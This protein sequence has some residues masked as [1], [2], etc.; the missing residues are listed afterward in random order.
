M[1][2]A[3]ALASANDYQDRSGVWFKVQAT[4]IQRL[5]GNFKAFKKMIFAY[6]GT[7]KTKTN[8]FAIIRTIQSNT[9]TKAEFRER[10]L[11]LHE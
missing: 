4:V 11:G 2:D 5:L 7:N 10:R 1:W 3:R 6:A 8:D 9:V